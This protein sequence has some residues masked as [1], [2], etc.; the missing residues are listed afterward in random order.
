MSIAGFLR[1]PLPDVGCK[2]AR[3]LAFE[4]FP[5]PALGNLL[6]DES[7]RVAH[8]VGKLLFRYRASEFEESKMVFVFQSIKAARVSG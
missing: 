2:K 1:E 7:G 6:V 5:E 3:S 8:P 4:V